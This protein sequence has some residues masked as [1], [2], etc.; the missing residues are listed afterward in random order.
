MACYLLGNQPMIILFSQHQQNCTYAHWHS[1]IV[2]FDIYRMT[3]PS[4]SLF[5]NYFPAV[6]FNAFT[7]YNLPSKDNSFHEG[8]KM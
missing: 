7:F 6:C 2:K 5:S 4:K 3:D 1:I 8:R